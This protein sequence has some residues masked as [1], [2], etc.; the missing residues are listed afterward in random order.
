M[1]EPPEV[2][3]C[4]IVYVVQP[5]DPSRKYQLLTFAGRLNGDGIPGLRQK[6]LASS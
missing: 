3:P 6:I 1:N 2:R 4:V 5:S